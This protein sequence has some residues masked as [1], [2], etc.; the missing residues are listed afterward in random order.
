MANKSATVTGGLVITAPEYFED[1]AFLAWLNN[2][3]GQGL[4]TWQSANEETLDAFCDCFVSLEPNLEGEGSDADMPEY[5]WE[6]ILA[7]C[8]EHFRPNQFNNH[9]IVRLSPC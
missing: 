1:Q 4:A 8:R 2:H 6:E 5:I 7:I 3:K 9:I